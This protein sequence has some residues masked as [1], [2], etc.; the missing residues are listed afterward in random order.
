MLVKICCEF[1]I[2]LLPIS[3]CFGEWAIFIK[4]FFKF[5]VILIKPL[6]RS[7]LISL[8]EDLLQNIDI[9][10]QYL[11]C[12]SKKDLT[13]ILCCW[14]VKI[15]LSLYKA[16]DYQ[17]WLSSFHSSSIVIPKNLTFFFPKPYFCL[18]GPT[19]DH[20]MT[21]TSSW[22]LSLSFH[23]VVFKPING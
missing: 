17:I 9:T 15:F 7:L 20:I 14:N 18:F 16:F 1:Q 21:N 6:F 19:D 10:G 12:A 4:K 8:L 5:W 22:H 13:S 2:F 23:T 3:E 11:N